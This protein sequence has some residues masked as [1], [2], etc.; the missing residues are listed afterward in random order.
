MPSI[1]FLVVGVLVLIV[2]GF[3][4]Y[5]VTRSDDGSPTATTSLPDDVVLLPQNP[6][7]ALVQENGVWYVE[8]DGNVT[9]SGVMVQGDEGDVVC[10]LATMSPQE[11]L[12]C[13]Q[14]AGLDELV[15]TGKGPQGQ[16]IEVRSD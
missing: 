16:E 2:A 15:V 5:A 14:A 6:S 1:A 9:M 13:E 7:L 11:R 12:A 3:L 8:N 4:V 10:E